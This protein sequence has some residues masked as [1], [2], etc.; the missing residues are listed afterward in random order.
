MKKVLFL[1]THLGSGSDTLFNV[2]T[3]HPRIDGF[4]TNMSYDHYDKIE[5]LISN[6]H[7]NNRSNSIWMDMLLYN[8]SFVCKPLIEMCYFV[9]LIREPKGSLAEII[10]TGDYTVESASRYYRYRLRGLCEYA[11]RSKGVILVQDRLSDLNKVMRY[12]GLKGDLSV[13]SQPDG[14]RCEI[15]EKILAECDYS[16]ELYLRHLKEAGLL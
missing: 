6:P 10:S 7:K 12:I 11:I 1:A 5:Q 3:S 15:P 16:Y 14:L 4:K 8:Y 13:S 2:L 9:F